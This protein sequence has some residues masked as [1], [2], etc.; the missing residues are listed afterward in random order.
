MGHIGNNHARSYIS[1]DKAE[2]AA[3]CDIRLD[4]AKAASEKYGVPYYLD[5]QQMLDEIKPDIVSVSTGGFEYSSDH[6]QPTLQALRAGADV[7]CEKPICNDLR[8][9]K[10]MVDTAKALGRRF[11]LD[12][13]HR[14]TPAARA[15]DKWQRDGRIGEL[16]FVNM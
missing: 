9:G 6:Y 15:A 3:V 13:N 1:S 11:A 8:K 10:E 4:R 14:F 7:I 5:A 2:L 16:L 12:L